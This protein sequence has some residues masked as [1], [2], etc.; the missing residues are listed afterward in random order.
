MVIEMMEKISLFG[1]DSDYVIV[2]TES[3]SSPNK[4]P[5]V[6]KHFQVRHLNLFEFF[7]D[8]GWQFSLSKKI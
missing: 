4:I 8:N 6:C 7:E 2:S 3:E 5:A 1:N